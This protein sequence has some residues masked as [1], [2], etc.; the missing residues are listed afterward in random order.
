MEAGGPGLRPRAHRVDEDKAAT[1]V[2]IVTGYGTV[3]RAIVATK[4]G[5]FWFL[6]KP[7]EYE[8]LQK[9]VEKAL[10]RQEFRRD[11]NQ[12]ME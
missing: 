10:E 9:L 8:V 5:A 7:F 12:N 4:A 3:D 1:P 2:V 6:E 11:S